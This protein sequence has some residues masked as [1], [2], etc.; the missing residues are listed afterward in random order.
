METLSSSK[1]IAIKSKSR[2][3]ENQQWI[4]QAI[5]KIA[6]AFCSSVPVSGSFSRSALNLSAEAKTELS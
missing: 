5:A 6:A 4:S 2:W 1:I 3:D